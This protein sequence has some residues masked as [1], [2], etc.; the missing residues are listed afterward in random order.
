MSVKQ[1]ATLTPL[2]KSFRGVGIL[3]GVVFESM[4]LKLGSS[5]GIFAQ[6]MI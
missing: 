2:A 1:H 4:T 6:D 5:S 3:G